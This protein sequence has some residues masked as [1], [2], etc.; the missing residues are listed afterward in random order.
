MKLIWKNGSVFH[1]G[2]FQRAD[3]SAEASF[4]REDCLIAG[5]EFVI[6][7]AFAD[8]HVHLREPGFSYKE[9]VRT[10]TLA[11]AAGGYTDV[12]A[13]PNLNPV[14]D[15]LMHL[16]AQQNIIREDAVIRV[17]PY[18]AI[19]AGEK[20]E[21]LADMDALAPFVLGFSDD[22]RGVQSREMMKKA[23]ETAKRL[24]KPIVAHCED[25]VLRAGGYIHAGAYCR[26]N[27]HKGISSESEWKPIERDLELVRETGCAYHVCHVSAK[28]SVELIRRA[29]REGL[30]VSCETAP[31]YLLLNDEQLRDEGKWKMNP[32]IRS[33]E[34]RLALIEGLL[35]GTVDM[36]ITDHA[37]HSAEEKAGGLEKSAMGIVGLETAFP[38]LYTGLVKTGIV[39]FSLLMEKM[40][41]A[42]R[43]R[44]ALPERLNDFC[45][46]AMEEA[47]EIDPARF[48]SMGK[49]TPFEG[50][51]V[52]GRCVATVMDGKLVWM[53]E[54]AR[55]Q[56]G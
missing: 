55:R 22:G 47:Y 30:D 41:Y 36:I 6:L 19:T 29:K 16:R 52:Y 7:P 14:P 2:A 4:L 24:R 9:T 56:I 45:V 34:D 28:E 38:L 46:W 3:K 53:N 25:D 32:P 21:V 26:R 54:E 11:A 39:P 15:T 5:E 18:G 1:N 40:V 43:K 10:G 51:R 31:H 37:P 49:S 35:D 23:M 20:G 27:G 48:L 17:H 12:G 42:P 44:F 50:Q 33:E 8:V 13:M